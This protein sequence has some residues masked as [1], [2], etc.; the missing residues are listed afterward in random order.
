MLAN[1]AKIIYDLGLKDLRGK[2]VQPT[3][4]H[5]TVYTAY[6]LAIAGIDNGRYVSYDD[7]R[8]AAEKLKA[9]S[10][11]GIT[12]RTRQGEI[13][14]RRDQLVLYFVGESST[15]IKGKYAIPPFDSIEI[16]DFSPDIKRLE[17]LLN[18]DTLNAT[19]WADALEKYYSNSSN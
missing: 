15:E 17:Q 8:E 19:Q 14:I 16:K 3:E 2:P 4:L 13:Y 6:V 11:E 12:Q 5:I 18:S 7:M 1:N 9:A 10:F